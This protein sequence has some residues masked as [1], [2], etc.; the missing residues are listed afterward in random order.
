MGNQGGERK[1]GKNKQTNQQAPQTTL[2]LHRTP[3][4]ATECGWIGRPLIPLK[5]H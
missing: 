1:G 4:D 5:K 2:T 3:H